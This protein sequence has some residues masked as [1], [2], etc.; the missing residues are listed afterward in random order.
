MLERMRFTGVW[1]DYQARVLDAMNAHI[2][3]ERLHLV[4]APGAGK[5]VLGLEI[6]RRLGRPA[7]VF[8][9]TV[10][11]REQ[12]LQRLCP[13]FLGEPPAADE[14][15]RELAD[16]RA[17]TL[18]T[19]QALGSIRR[20]DDELG[21]LIETLNAAGPWTLVLDEAH[22]LRREWWRCLEALASGLTDVRILALTAT[23]PYDAGFDEWSRY[24]NLCGPIDFEIGIPE[25]VRNGD[26]C[27]H[28]DHV[29]LSEP[30]ADA[31]MQLDR[32]R[33]A[34][35]A[36]QDDLRGDTALLD[37][38]LAHPWLTE[39]EAH[40]EAILEAP[41]M[42]SAVLVLLGSAGREL[43]A[44]PL[45][46]LGA[47]P[48]DLPAPSLFWL[49][50]FLDGVAGKSA[51]AFPLGADR[52]KDLRGRL[53]REG[54]IE[55]G[56]VRLWQTRAVFQLLASS[57]AKLASIAEIARAEEASLGGS[58]R[59]VILSDHIRAGE[60]PADPG[61]GFTPAK[62][63]VVPIFETLRRA[64]AAR[65]GLG[66]L[67]GS[68]VIVPRAALGSIADAAA[69]ARLDPGA[70]LR[71]PLPAC[72]DHVRLETAAGGSADLVRLVTALFADG[73]IRVLVG[74]QSL[75][76]EGWDAP[77][78]NSLVL[79]S[80]AASFMLSNQMRGRA[81]R[82]DPSV[83][84]KVANVWHL[85]T[86]EP[87]D[88]SFWTEA[89][90]ML[91]WGYLNDGGPGGLSDAQQL[92]RRFKAFEGISNSDSALIESGIG[93]LGIDPA[94]PAAESNRR[95]FVLAAD[96]AATAGRW[97]RSLGEGT[98]RSR[99]RET[100]APAYAPRHLSQY[101]TLQG[102]AWSALGSGAFAVA[103][104]LRQAGSFETLGEIGMGLAGAGTLA[105]LPRLARAARLAWRNG[106]LESSLEAVGLTALRAL[107]HA[108]IAS[109]DELSNAEFEV[110]SSL[111]GRK[112]VV[113]R[114]VSRS[115]ERQVMQA[116]AEI[117]GP[118]QNPRYLLVRKTRLGWKR[119][120][121]YHAVPA[122]IG[123]RKDNAEAFA[124]LWRQHVG[125]SD[126]VFTR[127]A[128]GR[129][130]LLRARTASFASGFQRSVDRR[131][132]W[133]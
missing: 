6:V 15:S 79:A 131:S 96:R 26:L 24:E 38:L 116:L 100:A 34:I 113:L 45:A 9:P 95:T 99:V 88:R 10:A 86:I 127:M 120:A 115:T 73:K 114:G 4:A 90:E 130:T 62:L 111:D 61:A 89:A 25:L 104:E 72:P 65:D 87:A 19:Y 11:I 22:H 118:V 32:R 46:L 56:K 5:T 49:E 42:L 64:G 126:L 40:V 66:V 50:R 17:I 112:D 35:A 129:R 133:L 119:R 105:T 125:A 75:L 71:S 27:P 106:S 21:R 123:T 39:P 121:D 67:T 47:A 55:G 12:W 80:N 33:A 117:L 2:G 20:G 83:P 69:S 103:N 48:K 85:A 36:L 30:S 41:E 109:E 28:Q 23:P 8:A 59:M 93:R 92:A 70:I 128:E 122:A 76:G 3:D 1:R 54:L 82:K 18:A 44:A 97:S 107:G 13:L 101:D 132:V 91:N 63:G 37:G 102:L 108:G 51:A 43:P 77:A 81:I 57:L 78:L 16:P 60:L 110:R 98:E 14:V 84:C 29:V 68:L 124:T 53:H 7:L 94:A 74:T 58:L 31:L 52:L